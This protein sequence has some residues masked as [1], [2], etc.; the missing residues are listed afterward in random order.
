M[1][2]SLTKQTRLEE[3]KSVGGGGRNQ[4][5]VRALCTH[6]GVLGYSGRLE[7]ITGWREYTLSLYSRYDQ[8]EWYSQG[9]VSQT[10][11]IEG[12]TVQRSSQSDSTCVGVPWL[13]RCFRPS[14]A[15]E[16]RGF[17]VMCTQIEAHRH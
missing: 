8:S 12:H 10:W 1:K 6:T 5:T 9:R 17:N 2:L 16:R 13:C 3:K 15:G 11:S 7:L 4:I 14:K